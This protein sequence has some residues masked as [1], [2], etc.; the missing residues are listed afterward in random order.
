VAPSVTCGQNAYGNE[1][2]RRVATALVT[3]AD[4]AGG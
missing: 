4:L 2:Q 1:N 3:I